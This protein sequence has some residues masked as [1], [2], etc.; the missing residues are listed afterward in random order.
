MPFLLFHL[1]SI[2]FSLEI[3]LKPVSNTYGKSYMSGKLLIVSSRG[4]TDLVSPDGSVIN[5][6]VVEA[7]VKVASGPQ[8][9]IRAKMESTIATE[10]W[11]NAFHN[12]TFS[13]TPGKLFNFKNYF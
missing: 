7:G 2:Y 6:N 4:N 11:Y 5:A 9:N 3:W 8:M 12:Y 1:I 10:P 13:W